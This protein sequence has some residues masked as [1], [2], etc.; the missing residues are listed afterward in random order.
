ML[1][2]RR[3]DLWNRSVTSSKTK[4]QGCYSLLHLPSLFWSAR[5]ASL[6]AFGWLDSLI[7]SR[8]QQWMTIGSWLTRCMQL[9]SC[10]DKTR[11]SR[12]YT[13]N[14]YTS[15]QVGRGFQ[16]LHQLDAL[17]FDRICLQKGNVQTRTSDKKPQYPTNRNKGQLIMDQGFH[18]QPDW[19]RSWDGL[20]MKLQCEHHNLDK[21]SLSLTWI[22]NVQTILSLIM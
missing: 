13:V 21:H 11:N 17:L 3:N 19:S 22:Q 7:G 8:H 1:K 18:G 15:S 20:C 5:N 2:A 10:V 16:L 14:C 9:V 4:L 12:C 6:S